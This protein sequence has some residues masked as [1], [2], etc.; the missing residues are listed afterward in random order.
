MGNGE[1]KNLISF[2]QVKDGV[3]KPF[4]LASLRGS[5]LLKGPALRSQ[6]NFRDGHF[7]NVQVTTRCTRIASMVVRR[8]IFG[9]QPCFEMI[10]DGLQPYFALSSAIT[11]AAGIVLILPDR[12]SSMRLTSSDFHARFQSFREIFS[13]RGSSDSQSCFARRSRA[14]LGSARA[15]STTCFCAAA[16]ISEI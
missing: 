10:R 6:L 2:I 16:V 4:H 13:S 9:F 7:E 12:I 11:R 15:F 3:R 14:F 5:S 8:G 1:D